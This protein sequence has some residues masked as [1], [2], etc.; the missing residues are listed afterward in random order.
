MGRRNVRTD[1]P[2]ERT[3]TKILEVVLEL[4]DPAD[5][6]PGLRVMSFVERGP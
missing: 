1:D 5:L 2:T 6:V 3:D 4:E